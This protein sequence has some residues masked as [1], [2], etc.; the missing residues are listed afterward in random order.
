MSANY[1]YKTN[2]GSALCGDSKEL[3]AN[4]SDESIDLV[5]TSPPFA[6][7]RQKDYGNIE[8]KNS[9]NSFTKN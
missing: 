6:L 5:M 2:C 8:Q 3:L 9:L 7:Q 1:S 4:L